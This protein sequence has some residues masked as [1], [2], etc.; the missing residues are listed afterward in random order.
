MYYARYCK[1]YRTPF[2]C[3]ADNKKPKCN[4]K[5][6]VDKCYRRF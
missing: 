1:Y 6:C 4:R 2:R 5:C 3:G